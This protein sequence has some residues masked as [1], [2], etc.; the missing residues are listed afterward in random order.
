MKK[1]ITVLLL[2]A[3]LF[4]AACLAWRVGYAMR[5]SND[6]LP[7]LAAV[8]QMSEADVNSLLAGYRVIQLREVWGD[9]AES[10]ENEDI[11]EIGGVTLT[12][13]YKNDGKV[14]VCGLKDASGRSVG[15]S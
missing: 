11:W 10:S 4:L 5:K 9:P 15:E 14:A 13:N 7:A 12:V 8:A 3:A 2:A 6:N 1:K